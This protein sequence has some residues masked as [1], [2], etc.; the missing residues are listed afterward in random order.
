MNEY[1][2]SKINGKTEFININ[3]IKDSKF[4][5]LCE[6][7]NILTPMKINLKINKFLNIKLPN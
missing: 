4:E 3:D 7:L 6:K 5:N 2:K 1:L